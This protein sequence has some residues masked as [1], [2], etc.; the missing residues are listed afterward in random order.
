MERCE[1]YVT[2]NNIF[3]SKGGETDE[4]MNKEGAGMFWEMQ[5]GEEYRRTRVMAMKQFRGGKE[6]AGKMVK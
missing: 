6:T 3:N 4:E 5:E 1:K 2:S